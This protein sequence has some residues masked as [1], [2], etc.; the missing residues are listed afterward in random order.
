MR[1]GA[2]LG[3]GGVER[4]NHGRYLVD[5]SRRGR[6]YPCD[7]IPRFYIP[8][9]QRLVSLDS[10][11]VPPTRARGK[12]TRDESLRESAGEANCITA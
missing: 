5:C 1:V 8:R 9:G 12:G 3:G 11:R 10:S 6:G 2:F 4:A 7:K